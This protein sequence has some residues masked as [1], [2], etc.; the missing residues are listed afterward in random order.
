MTTST[1]CLDG[2]TRHA[3]EKRGLDERRGRLVRVRRCVWCGKERTS[4]YET[5][6]R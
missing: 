1:T 5:R 4:A 6:K 2:G 3:W